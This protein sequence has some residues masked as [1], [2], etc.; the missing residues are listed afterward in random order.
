MGNRE[1]Q[2]FPIKKYSRFHLKFIV[3]V[4]I[5]FWVSLRM[6]ELQAISFN[7]LSHVRLRFNSFHNL[8]FLSF[9][10]RIAPFSSIETFL[11]FQILGTHSKHIFSTMTENDLFNLHHFH[12]LDL[13]FSLR[14]VKSMV[15]VL[16][17]IQVKLGES[18][19]YTFIIHSYICH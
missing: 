18:S 11:M 1:I 4:A 19:L 5:K 3:Y 16:A 13:R 17:T 10:L 7:L 6:F 15:R 2:D 8:H 9:M 14:Y 12:P